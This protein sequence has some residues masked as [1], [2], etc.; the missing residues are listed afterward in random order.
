MRTPAFYEAQPG[1]KIVWTTFGDE[2]SSQKRSI[3]KDLARLHL[4]TRG[5]EGDLD[6]LLR[7]ELMARAI[8]KL[9]RIFLKNED[10]TGVPGVSFAI[11]FT[12]QKPATLKPHDY[13]MCGDRG[14]RRRCRRCRAGPGGIPAAS[15]ADD[16]REE[17]AD[18]PMSQEDRVPRRRTRRRALPAAASARGPDPLFVDG[19]PVPSR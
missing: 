9:N 14:R 16:L 3:E 18:P 5:Y 1:T 13:W 19:L 8:G 7:D 10:G 17:R 2:K 4:G 6:A 12:D 11:S 15:P